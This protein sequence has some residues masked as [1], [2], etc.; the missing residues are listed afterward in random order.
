MYKRQP[1]DSD[2]FI[3]EAHKRFDS[4]EDGISAHV[5][6]LALYAGAAGYPKEGTLDP[7][8]FE[9]LF[10][11]CPTDVYKRQAYYCDSN[12]SYWRGY[13][14][15]QD[16]TTYDMATPELFYESAVAFGHFQNML[17]AYPAGSLH[18]TIANFH[19]TPLRYEALEEAVAADVCGRV[20][21]V[22]AEIAFW[23]ER[24]EMCIRDRRIRNCMGN[25]F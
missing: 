4:W 6:H 9:S 5:D 15:I 17:A 23:R 18:E 20:K 1:E 3:A 24:K 8:H 13:A 25:Y 22:A 12:G 21:E 14:F 16:A 2:D 19:N 11:R 10:G 7:R